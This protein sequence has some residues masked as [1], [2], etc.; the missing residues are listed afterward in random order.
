S[1]LTQSLLQRKLF[2]PSLLEVF[3]YGVEEIDLGFGGLV[4][5]SDCRSIN[6]SALWLI[7]GMETLKEL[8]FS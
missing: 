7:A 2:S 4:S 5:F 8:E 1:K 6:S 3:Q